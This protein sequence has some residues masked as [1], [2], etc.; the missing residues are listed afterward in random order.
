[1]QNIND[2]GKLIT[3]HKEI[4]KTLDQFFCDIPKNKKIEN[5][6]LGT[7]KSYQDY[8]INPIENIFNLDPTNTSQ[9]TKQLKAALNFE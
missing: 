3:N 7:H 1:M 6:I 5:K 9:F 4:A 2:N 8:L